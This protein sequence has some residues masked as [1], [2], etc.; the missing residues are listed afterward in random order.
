[1]QTNIALT[2]FLACLEQIGERSEQ[3][4][5]LADTLLADWNRVYQAWSNHMR[6]EAASVG[7]NFAA[8]R[9]AMNDFNRESKAFE[10]KYGT[11]FDPYARPHQ[12]RLS[13]PEV[14]DRVPNPM[15][16]VA[17]II[18]QDEGLR[19]ITITSGA[20]ACQTVEVPNE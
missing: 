7:Y 8:G 15:P 20:G 13:A 5:G 16:S 11:R 4:H 10:E 2:G 19:T 12:D 9:E 6:I 18:R 1:M 14:Q 3:R 17:A